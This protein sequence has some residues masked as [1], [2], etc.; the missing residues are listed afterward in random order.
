MDVG[1]GRSLVPVANMT[2]FVSRT[3]I[4]VKHRTEEPFVGVPQKT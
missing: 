1:K 4:A 3:A 2:E